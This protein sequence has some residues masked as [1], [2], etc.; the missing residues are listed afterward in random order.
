MMN[1]SL[2]DFLPSYP[3]YKQKI[4]NDPLFNVYEGDIDSIL[5]RK[6]EFQ[7]L[8]K[9]GK[10]VSLTKSIMDQISTPIIVLFD[11]C[12]CKIEGFCQ[13][14]NQVLYEELARS[15]SFNI[16][17][18][19]G[20]ELGIVEY[21][22]L[23]IIKNKKIVSSYIGPYE[24]ESIKNW[25]HEKMES[26]Y[27]EHVELF[28]HQQFIDRFLS[29]NTPY[30]SLLIWHE[31]GTGK[32]LTSIAV[33]LSNQK[34]QSLP[35][36][37]LV[38]GPNIKLNFESQLQKYIPYYKKNSF[39][40]QTFHTFCKHIESNL[41]PKFI[42][43]YY[44]N[45]TIII[46]EVHNIKEKEVEEKEH[47]DKV[48]NYS[49]LKKFLHMVQDCKILLMSATPIKDNISEF[50]SI[51]NL[52]LPKEKQMRK[53][54]FHS[55]YFKGNEFKPIRLEQLKNKIKGYISYL[56]Q[57][58][59]N[60]QVRYEGTNL[61]IYKEEDDSKEEVLDLP[62]NTFPVVL[63]E[64]Q[65]E[66]STHYKLAKQTDDETEGG[67]KKKKTHGLY[68]NSR[69]AILST[70]PNQGG[71]YYG[72]FGH[73]SYDMIIKSIFED[74]KYDRLFEKEYDP[75]VSD[76]FIKEAGDL[77]TFHKNLY[78]LKQYSIK[79]HYLIRLFFLRKYE[80][81]KMFVYFKLIEGSA[82]YLL[83]AILK[84]FQ[85]SQVKH[86]N[87][88]KEEG[89]RF[90]TITSKTESPEK[91]LQLCNHE[92]N[93]QGR[94]IRFL[95]GSGTMAEGRSLYYFR[96]VI[97]MNPH[98]NYTETEQAIGRIIRA[99]SHDR[100]E[101]SER[102][103]TVHQL[104]SYQKGSEPIKERL[105]N[106]IDHYMYSTSFL[107]DY[108]IKKIE[109][110]ARETSIDCVFNKDRNARKLGINHSR[111]CFYQNCEYTCSYEPTAELVKNINQQLIKDTYHLFYNE[112]DYQNIK[113]IL[114]ILFLSNFSYPI[115]II[116]YIV[117][118]D[119]DNTS[120]IPETVVI[121][122]LNELMI[123]KEVFINPYGFESYLN[124][125]RNSYFL[126]LN[127]Y[128][129]NLY[130]LYD[131][132]YPFF[133][134]PKDQY[135]NY[136]DYMELESMPRLFEF[137]KKY[138][139][140]IIKKIVSHLSNEINYR[141]FSEI[142]SSPKNPFIKKMIEVGQSLKFIAVIDDQFVINK[143][144]QLSMEDKQN[145][146]NELYLSDRKEN[147]IYL[148][149]IMDGN[150]LKL[151][152]NTTTLL[153]NGQIKHINMT[154]GKFG[155]GSECSDMKI[156]TLKSFA[157]LLDIHSDNRIVMCKEIEKKLLNRRFK[158][159]P[160]QNLILSKEDH[161]FMKDYLTPKKK[162]VLKKIKKQLEEPEK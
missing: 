34:Y 113:T 108:F 19:N 94:Y 70:Y 33:A 8:L 88:C 59:S 162:Q 61:I 131:S 136:L 1:M 137:M 150:K 103:I 27:K 160:N 95:L 51:M 17:K 138:D 80:S 31:M 117:N 89:I 105:G 84:Y 49:V 42:N 152:N 39:Q 7:E 55:N 97:I 98:W 54:F 140:E 91:I 16:Y 72:N 73:L 68:T 11:S 58:Q 130:D 119:K 57:D 161:L 124:E 101:K 106:S 141:I 126:T 22:S 62:N 21:P 158:S 15:L 143:P 128:K 135:M 114:Q 29:G 86:P 120:L 50:A 87:D 104:I 151:I 122:C 60:V 127:K 41:N 118:K 134:L 12:E 26:S 52:I 159:V 132:Q 155:G 24:I 64:M 9:K 46:D 23:T 157:E 32:T 77:K 35:P 96:H 145:I 10:V 121:R 153:D 115:E 81:Q 156:Q 13:C 107:K 18:A 25:I 75:S 36:L 112:I 38:K 43:E 40:I 85:I 28:Q 30:S 47:S 90:A 78:K 133:S 148:Y 76:D 82:L 102:N 71:N 154:N 139:T 109:S 125:H 2:E 4:N 48:K 147:S 123:K 74:K 69:Q 142:V 93:D 14:E 144:V 63:L 83:E 44:S 67:P 5:Y 110:I 66:Q 92:N 65:E 149:G 53:K 100:L 20:P 45:R 116:L 129:T 79:Y 37:I 6:N 3:L 56:R 99:D 146:A 111:E